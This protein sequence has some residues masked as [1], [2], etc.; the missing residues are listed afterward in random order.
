MSNELFKVALVGCGVIS[1][2]HL[3]ALTENENVQIVALCDNKP[4]RTARRVSEYGIVN[5]KEYL[6]YEEMLDT[7]VLDAVHICTPHYLHAEMTIAALKRNINVF[8]E[9]P[10]AIN[11]QELEDMMEAERNS[12]ARVCICFQNRYN[13]STILVKKLVEEDGGATSAFGSLFWERSTEY[14]TESDWRGRY[15]TEGGGVMINQAIHTI[16]LLCEFLGKPIAVTATTANHKHKGIIEVEDTCEGLIEFEGG[17]QGNFFA[18]TASTGSEYTMIRIRTPKR[19]ISLM[20]PHVYVNNVQVDDPSLV[21]DYVGK[22][23]YGNGH[24]YLIKKFYKALKNGTEIPVPLPRSQYALR[25]LLGAY[26][27]NDQRVEI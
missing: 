24:K 10:T 18:T 26:Q 8:L 2:N 14:Y 23:C 1:K 25:I 22:E 7:E 13:P 3:K 11:E 19:V 6:D 4:G 9:K 20:P 21:D 5:C 17:K 16:D 27:S 15:A 12:S